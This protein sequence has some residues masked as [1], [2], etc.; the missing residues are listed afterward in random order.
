MN[1]LDRVR[2]FRAGEERLSCFGY[3]GTLAAMAKRFGRCDVFDDKFDQKEAFATNTLQPMNAFDPESSFLEVV[4]PGIP[5]S[6]PS[7]ASAKHLISDYDFFSEGMPFSVWI[8]GTNGKTT[9]TQML[10]HL[11]ESRGALI[12]GNVGTPVAALDE[13]APMWILETS[14]F[15]L[16]YTRYATPNIYLLLPIREDHI[17]WHGSFKA[18]VADKLKPLQ[19]MKEGELA[20]IPKEYAGQVRSDAFV[21]GYESADDLAAYFGIDPEQIRFNP[22]FKFDAIMALAV[23]KSLYNEVDY[24]LLNRFV[25]DPHKLEEF[26]DGKGRL[27]VDDSKATNVDATVAGLEGYA[28]RY[29]HLILGGDDK[30]ADMKP[31]VEALAERGDI[32]TYLIGTNRPKMAALCGELSVPFEECGFLDIAVARIDQAME[33]NHVAVLSPAAASLDQFTSYK[34]R[35]EKFQ[36]FVK[37]LG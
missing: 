15:T 34:E 24:D 21:V 19:G 10:G 27:W 5:P 26:E 36:E 1:V 14:S 3:G 8:S 6:N 29:V 12:G 28:G 2:A 17:S 35:G 33:K 32:R 25:L 31:L 20:I 11:L 16:H 9:T 7:V 13:A 37:K 4:T 30:G 22:P 18:Y 23:T